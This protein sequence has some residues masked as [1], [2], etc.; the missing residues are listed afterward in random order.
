MDT[1]ICDCSIVEFLFV[2]EQ[3]VN[4]PLPHLVQGQGGY[5]T[6]VKESKGNVRGPLNDNLSLH[7]KQEPTNSTPLG[8]YLTTYLLK[9][10]PKPSQA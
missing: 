7:S 1:P 5:Q 6:N 8:Y 9:H 2:L 3:S 10:P 4:S